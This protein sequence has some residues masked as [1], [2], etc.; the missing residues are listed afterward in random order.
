[1]RLA[2][3][4]LLS[5]G[6]ACVLAIIAALL[7]QISLLLLGAIISHFAFWGYWWSR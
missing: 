4:A 1:M 7:F 6:L 3:K 5:D 2:Y